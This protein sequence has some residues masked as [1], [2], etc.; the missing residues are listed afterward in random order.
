[1][2][3]DK[4]MKPMFMIIC[5]ASLNVIMPGRVN[6]ILSWTKYP[7]LR[8][9]ITKEEMESNFVNCGYILVF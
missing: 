7:Q 1:M 6:F 3:S 9:G 4:L 2:R 5:I 8:W